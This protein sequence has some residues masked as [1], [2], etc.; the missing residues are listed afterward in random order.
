MC[1]QNT[2][3]APA[4]ER[5]IKDCGMEFATL[6]TVCGL[7]IMSATTCPKGC[8]AYLPKLASAS[9]E[10][11]IASDLAGTSMMFKKMEEKLFK[12]CTGV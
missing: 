9:P 2:F 3:D 11:A 7:E 1:G 4:R 6:Q 5:V 10:C 12:L 8:K